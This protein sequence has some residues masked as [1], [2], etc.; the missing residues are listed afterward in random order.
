M[1]KSVKDEIIR[2]LKESGMYG[3]Y[4]RESIRMNKHDNKVIGVK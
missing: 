4:K 1:K 2:Q 3:H